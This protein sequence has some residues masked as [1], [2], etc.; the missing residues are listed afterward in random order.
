MTTVLIGLG[1]P[2]CGDDAVG[3]RVAERVQALLAARPVA[4]ARVVTSTRGGFELL[5]LLSGYDRAI[6][7]DCLATEGAVPGTVRELD[8]HDV[9]GCPRLVGGHDIGLAEVVELGRVVGA[10]MPERIEIVAVEADGVDRIEERLSPAVASQVEPLARQLHQ[11]LAEAAGRGAE[12]SG[13]Q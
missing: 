9:R 6:V 2:V 8:L 5:E 1:N 11:R 13:M 12:V 10:R 4:G 7:V 3:L